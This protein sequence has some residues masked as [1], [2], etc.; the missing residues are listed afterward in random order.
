MDCGG[1][2]CLRC[3]PT[4]RCRR[5]LRARSV[6]EWLLRLAAVRLPR[7]RAGGCQQ[8]ILRVRWWSMELPMRWP[9]V[10][11][12]LRP[13][14]VRGRRPRSGLRTRRGDVLELQVRHVVRLSSGTMR[15]VLRGRAHQHI[16]VLQSLERLFR[17]QRRRLRAWCGLLVVRERD[18]LRGAQQRRRAMPM[19]KGRSRRGARGSV[20]PPSVHAPA[21]RI[22]VCPCACPSPTCFSASPTSL[23]A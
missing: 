15:P 18:A 1:K 10:R 17:H 2:S 11:G 6:R 12:V 19:R 8:W 3:W 21:I 23:S 13:D 16:G 20:A 22:T 14:G 7:T 5:R 9:L 4:Q